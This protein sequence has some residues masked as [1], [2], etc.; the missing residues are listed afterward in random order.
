MEWAES[1]DE[2]VIQR[3]N[4]HQSQ[5]DLLLGD[6]NTGQTSLLFSERDEAWLN[7]NNDLHWIDNGEGFTWTSDRDGFSHVYLYDR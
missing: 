3:L 7:A 5:L 6:A 1:S 2:V 4:R